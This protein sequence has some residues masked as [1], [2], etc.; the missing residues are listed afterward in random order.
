M[1][2]AGESIGEG[3]DGAA[4]VCEGADLRAAETDAEADED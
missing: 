4:S 1:E 2:A 3:P